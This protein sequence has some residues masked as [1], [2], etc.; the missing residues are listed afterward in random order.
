MLFNSKEYDFPIYEPVSLF[1]VNVCNFNTNPKRLRKLTGLGINAETYRKN[2]FADAMKA[3]RDGWEGSPFDSDGWPTTDASIVVWEGKDP[4]SVLGTYLLQFSGK[5]YV[6]AVATTCYFYVDG[7]SQGTSLSS[8]VG[9]D[10]GTNKTTA[11]FTVDPTSILHLQFYSTQRTAASATNTG[12]TNVKIMRPTSP[13]ATTYYSPNTLFDSNVIN[14]FKK[15]T[16]IRWLGANQDITQVNWSDRILPSYHVAVDATNS[17]DEVWEFLVALANETNLDLYITIPMRCT[18]DYVTNLANLIRY[19][20]DGVDPYTSSQANP[21]YAGLKS[22]LNIYVEWSNEVWN[23]S[24]TQAGAG[25]EDAAAAVANNTSEGQ[26]INFDGN[27]SGGD[28]RRWAALKAVETSNIFRS[29]FGDAAMGDRVRILY[30]YQYDNFNG[31]ALEAYGFIDNYFN[32]GD[33]IQHVATPHPVNYFFWGGGGAVYYDAGGTN[34]TQSTVIFSDP[35]F[36]SVTLTAGTAVVA[37]SG[38]PWTFTGNCGVYR[39]ASPVVSIGSIGTPP[40]APVGNNALFIGDT[41]TV[42]QAIDFPSAGIYSLQFT[43]A[44][45]SSNANAIRIYVD[46]VEATPSNMFQNDHRVFNDPW[47]PNANAFNR[48]FPNTYYYASSAPFAVTAG[49]HTIE[50]VGT[51]S[52]GEYLF[53]DDFS[54][55]SLEVIF[56]DLADYRSSYAAQFITRASYAKLYGL[57][58]VAY[59]G[60]WA[61]GADLGG[62]P[63]QNYAKYVDP[64]AKQVQL[65]SIADFLSSGSDLYMLGSY[66]QWPVRDDVN[67]ASYPLVQAVIETNP[68]Y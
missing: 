64:R 2:V 67:A 65:D 28:Y 12:V 19:G 41:G 53:L 22:N 18:Q 51:G 6:W 17:H 13:G 15:Y 62:S 7:V 57:N 39:Q 10:S 50:V 56:S 20:S 36:E 49:T 45:P 9:Y 52:S 1:G 24:F 61:L 16:A 37:P 54:I 4:Q 40:A 44:F 35:S 8:G 58:V 21:V 38:T 32:N 66:E 14:A 55:L 63:L 34:G 42:S 27:A 48:N 26:I 3:S 30:E 33:G 60:G 59:E 46:S 43:S 29:V 31:T 25:A 23:W 5:A 11:E 68:P 47:T